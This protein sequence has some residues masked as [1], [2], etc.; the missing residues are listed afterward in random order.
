LLNDPYAQY[1]YKNRKFLGF[2]QDK[3][4]SMLLT[5][6]L[7][8]NPSSLLFIVGWFLRRTKRHTAAMAAFNKFMYSALKANSRVSGVIIQISGRFNNRARVSKKTFIYGLNFSLHTFS[9]AVVYSYK[10]I[11]TRIGSFGVKV[12][13]L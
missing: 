2:K 8:K 13:M 6:F 5:S 10:S 11:T 1:V 12:W 9:N 4:F 3:L 7:N